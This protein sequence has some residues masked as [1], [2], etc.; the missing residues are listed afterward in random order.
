M[1]KREKEW[2]LPNKMNLLP[3]L[4]KQVDYWVSWSTALTV[5]PSVPNTTKIWRFSLGIELSPQWIET[6]IALYLFEQLTLSIFNFWRLLNW[7]HEEQ[8][9]PQSSVGGKSMDTC[10]LS[11][12]RQR[13]KRTHA[14]GWICTDWEQRQLMIAYQKVRFLPSSHFGEWASS[15]GL[16]PQ[17]IWLYWDSAFFNLAGVRW[18][19]APPPHSPPLW[20]S[21]PSEWGDSERQPDRHCHHLRTLWIKQSSYYK[22]LI[23]FPV[24]VLKKEKKQN[25]DRQRKMYDSHYYIFFFPD[26]IYKW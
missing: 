7:F 18:E 4:A 11:L 13:I 25:N 1:V 8:A 23:V 5:L 14:A 26:T 17:R 9:L 24:T 22:F 19:W 15:S 20:S 2:F 12:L 10:C 3:V 16:S 6:F 21:F